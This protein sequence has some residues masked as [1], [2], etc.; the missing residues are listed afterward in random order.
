[1][2]EDKV[3]YVC[4]EGVE[5]A[6]PEAVKAVW[7]NE[8]AIAMQYALAQVQTE[9]EVAMEATRWPAEY[10][11]YL[12]AARNAKWELAKRAEQAQARRGGAVDDSV[13]AARVERDRFQTYETYAE[14]LAAVRRLDTL[15]KLGRMGQERLD[16]EAWLCAGPARP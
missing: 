16:L 9:H 6:T 12:A 2:D 13:Q 15:A 8:H 10:W 5:T 7:F 1:M 3:P 11:Q 4:G 14:W